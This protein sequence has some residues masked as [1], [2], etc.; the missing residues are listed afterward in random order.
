MAIQVGVKVE[1]MVCLKNTDNTSESAADLL[2]FLETWDQTYKAEVEKIPMFNPLL[3]KEWSL[4]QKRFFT[5]AFY[6][7]RGHFHTFLWQLGNFAPDEKSK[8]EILYNIEEEFGGDGKSHEQLYFQFAYA[9]G[10]DL[11][12]EVIKGETYLPLMKNFNEQHLGWI[13]THE[14]PHCFAA[15]SAYERLDNIDYYNLYI[16]LKGFNIAEA[17]L[18]FFLVHMQASHF[19]RTFTGLLKFWLDDQGIVQD[20]FS[21]IGAHQIKMW[22]A[23]SNEIFKHE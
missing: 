9:V 15:F 12:H 11:K 23:F 6:H 5:R 10:V 1:K 19:N 17:D 13:Q 18:T 8:K 20:A 16:L 4:A 14:W 3:T 22:K 2:S 21:F 7:A